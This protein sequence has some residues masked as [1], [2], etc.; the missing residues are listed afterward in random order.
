MPSSRFSSMCRIAFASWGFF[1][2]ISPVACMRDALL[3]WLCV[4]T[5][6][7]CKQPPCWLFILA[8]PSRLLFACHSLFIFLA[9][10]PLKIW[11]QTRGEKCVAHG[12]KHDLVSA[13]AFCFYVLWL[14]QACCQTKRATKRTAVCRRALFVMLTL[15]RDN[16]ILSVRNNDPMWGAWLMFLL[17][18]C[19]LVY[20]CV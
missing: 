14:G 8:P 18:V 15:D 7:L 5:A 9:F 2:C 16:L 3:P 12:L 19:G 13:P 1:L 6:F 20:L 4:R 10:V 17:R 11:V